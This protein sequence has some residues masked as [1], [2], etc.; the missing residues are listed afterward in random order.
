MQSDLF[1]LHAELEETHWWFVARRNIMRALVTKILPPRRDRIV[2]DV[3]CGTGANIAALS[4]AYVAIGID[5]SDEAIAIASRRYP[6]SRFVRGHAPEAL[7]E[8]A[9]MAD[10]FLSMDV[11]EHVD[12]F[13]MLSSLLASAKP[14]ALFYIN[15]P[16]DRALWSGHDEAFGHLRR[17][18]PERLRLAWAGLPVT[19]L[20]ISHFSSRLYP[21]VLAVR[22]FSR[23]R[24]VPFGELG[25]D[26]RLPPVA[27]NR[28]LTR[29]FSGEARR[30]DDALDGRAKPY[31][32]GSSLV[33]I[34]RR[35][36]GNV[37]PRAMPAGTDAAFAELAARS[38]R[39]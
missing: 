6:R 35:D 14:G 8:E 26:L 22:T 13:L 30:L 5:T 18:D 34:I 37:Q 2:V 28:A 31:A 32:F 20:L 19:T 15:V 9:R 21:I 33:A 7:G 16:A 23:L 25:T 38:I 17:Y 29:L 3:G 39:T 10:L 11:L 4:D 24:G 36:V 12:D 1:K 27:V